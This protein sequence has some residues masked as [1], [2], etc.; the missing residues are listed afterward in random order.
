V[1]AGLTRLTAVF[2]VAAPLAARADARDRVLTLQAALDRARSNARVMQSR[3]AAAAVSA[4]VDQSRAAWLPSARTTLT[5]ARASTNSMPL[6]ASQLPEPGQ[7]RAPQVGAATFYGGAL[8]VSQLIWD[9]GQAG[10]QLRSAGAQARA[11]SS[12]AAVV[13]ADVALQ[14][15]T[16]FYNALTASALLRIADE[17]V[18]RSSKQLEAARE[19]VR[20]GKRPHFDVTR[21][22]IDLAN[23]RVARLEADHAQVEGRLALAAAMGVED[24]GDVRLEPPAP[25]TDEDPRLEAVLARTLS[26][27]PELSAADA[28][29]L[30][31]QAL[32]EARRNSLYPSLSAAGRVTS[33]GVNPGG[34]TT[35]FNWLVGLQLD[36]SLLAGGADLAR[37]R[38]ETATLQALQAER[39][40]LVLQLRLEA[41]QLVNGVTAARARQEATH[42]IVLQARENLEIAEERYGAGVANIIELAD[43]QGTLTSA[44]AQNARAQFE[45]EVARARLRRAVG[46][47]D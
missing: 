47:P 11:A 9:F 1:V 6:P 15:R 5:V 37:L 20:V 21:A 7:A 45:L 31:Q 25:S 14:V 46:T 3:A 13:W 23:A 10:A 41:Q 29:L 8:E 4:R 28:R 24:L 32:V 44:E 43:A 22:Q 34:S 30:A 33:A 39:A 2:L 40:T 27:R 26:A 12:D 35:V 18:T 17:R 16:A 42:G 19:L 36:V 38:E